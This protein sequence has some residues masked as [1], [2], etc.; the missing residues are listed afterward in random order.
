MQHGARNGSWSA[1]MQKA[2]ANLSAE[3]I[4]AITAYIASRP[5]PASTKAASGAAPAAA[6]ARP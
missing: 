3:D 2:I 5:V 4:V 1:L 6:A